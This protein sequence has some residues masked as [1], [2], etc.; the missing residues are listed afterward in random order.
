[1][2]IE[3]VVRKGNFGQEAKTSYACLERRFYQRCNQERV[4]RDNETINFG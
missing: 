4:E 2:K 1:M 3:K